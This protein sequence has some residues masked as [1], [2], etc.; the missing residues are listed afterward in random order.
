MRLWKTTIVIWRNPREA[1]IEYLA[2]DATS[3]DSFCSKQ[4]SVFVKDAEGDPD[5]VGTDFSDKEES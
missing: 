3:G 4:A 2:R 1:E 5:W